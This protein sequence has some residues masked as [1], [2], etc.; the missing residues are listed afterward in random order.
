MT[1]IMRKT[2]QISVVKN[3]K[4]ISKRTLE[5]T[6][7]LFMSVMCKFAEISVVRITHV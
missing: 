7:L 4:L 3:H 5:S 6:S 2:K 1:V